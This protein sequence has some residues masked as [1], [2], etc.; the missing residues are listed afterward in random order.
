MPY[1]FVTPTEEEGPIGAHRLWWFYR[2][3]RGI[4]IVKTSEGYYETRSVSQEEMDTAEVVYLG[5][6]EYEV[7]DAEAAELTTAGYGSY[8]TEIV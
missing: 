1:K 7:S 6:H 3:D 8:L 2:L 4:S 5:G